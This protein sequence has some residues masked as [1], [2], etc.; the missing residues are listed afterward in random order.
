MRTRAQADV[1]FMS[2]NRNQFPSTPYGSIPKGL[3]ATVRA[4]L[5]SQQVV[6]VTGW[7]AGTEQTFRALCDLCCDVAI[8]MP[9]SPGPYPSPTGW[10]AALT[11]HKGILFEAGVEVASANRIVVHCLA[12]Q[13]ESLADEM[14]AR[15]SG[16]VYMDRD[17][18]TPPVGGRLFLQWV[19]RT[20][21]P[22]LTSPRSITDDVSGS[23]NRRGSNADR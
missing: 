18:D 5:T 17:M 15:I 4:A 20:E 11:S 12:E 10:Q 22:G 8:V 9:G 13:D 6:A 14:R 21:I 7:G 3:L 19:P 16:T 1:T 23:I 2:A